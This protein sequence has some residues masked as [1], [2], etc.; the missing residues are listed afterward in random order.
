MVL[1]RNIRI[2]VTGLRPGEKMFEELFIDDCCEQT[3]VAKVLSASE[4]CLAW[5]DLKVELETLRN[6]LLV[7]PREVIRKQLFD[8]VLS[9]NGIKARLPQQAD[10]S[11]IQDLPLM[12]AVQH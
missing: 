10:S 5:N 6:G 2:D 9:D 1:D 11:E 12:S 8:I 4:Q 7:E 3:S